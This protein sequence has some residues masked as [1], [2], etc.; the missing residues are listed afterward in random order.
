M[1]TPMETL[2]EKFK[3]LVLSEESLFNF[4]ILI[5]EFD[6]SIPHYIESFYHELFVNPLTSRKLKDSYI[7]ITLELPII[8]LGGDYLFFNA[9]FEMT[10]L[11]EIKF[12]FSRNYKK[13]IQELYSSFNI[14]FALF[15]NIDYKQKDFVYFEEL[16]SKYKFG[17][18]RLR[19]YDALFFP[20]EDFI[21]SYKNMK[22]L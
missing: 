5:D 22:F 18:L 21:F 13:Q 9:L 19:Y 10:T 4:N 14:F 17:W 6:F 8:E 1:E 12:E 16:E 3:K 15:G 2:R 11:K 20:L 7:K